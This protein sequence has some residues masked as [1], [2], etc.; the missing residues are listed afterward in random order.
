MYI[1]AAATVISYRREVP[2]YS[3]RVIHLRCLREPF[4]GDT[5]V[6]AR[7]RHD[8]AAI[9]R[10]LLAFHETRRRALLYNA[11]KQLLK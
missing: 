10:Q 1:G 8:E 3:Y 7:V 9:D 5:T 2:A 6:V 11:L 4:P